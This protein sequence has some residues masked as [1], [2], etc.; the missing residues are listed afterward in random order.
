MIGTC[1]ATVDFHGCR[2]VC[3]LKAGHRVVTGYTPDGAPE[4]VRI[5]VA[6]VRNSPLGHVDFRWV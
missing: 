6:R 4:W 3:S 5:H 2:F 1:G